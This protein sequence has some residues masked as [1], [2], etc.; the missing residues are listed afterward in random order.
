MSD[1]RSVAESGFQRLNR[2]LKNDVEPAVQCKTQVYKNGPVYV[3]SVRN[4]TCEAAG[5]E[6]RRYKWTGKS[7][8]FR[9]PGGYQCTP[10]G[11]GV[12]GYQ[13][14]CTQGVRVY[15]IEFAD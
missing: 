15:R 13:I 12:V 1:R 11:R 10:S 6:Q 3:T 5:R 2:A 14:R 9:T 8:S 4:L 7:M